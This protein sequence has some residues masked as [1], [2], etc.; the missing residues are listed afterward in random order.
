MSDTRT[1][2]IT[3]SGGIGLGSALSILFIALK[4]TGEIDWHWGWV[5]AP[6]WI[7]NALVA[8]VI[9]G[10]GVAIFVLW[11]VDRLSSGGRRGR[12]R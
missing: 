3:V 12:R 7:P 4:L 2:N 8:A 10:L 1:R 11:T 5:L 9:V 6:I